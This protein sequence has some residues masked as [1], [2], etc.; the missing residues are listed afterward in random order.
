MTSK[1]VTSNEPLCECARCVAIKNRLDDYETCNGTAHVA[2]VHEEL[3]CK[4]FPA[5]VSDEFMKMNKRALIP[6]ALPTQSTFAAAPELPANPVEVTTSCAPPP[7]VPTT[8][9]ANAWCER[10][11]KGHPKTTSD[12]RSALSKCS[13]KF[14]ILCSGCRGAQ[15]RVADQLVVKCGG[16]LEDEE[17]S[18]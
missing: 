4:L 3:V 1:S 5:L 7:S 18:D 9:Q 2:Y 11:G 13:E 14:A 12:L 8:H 16:K 17:D 10:C 15:V 6:A